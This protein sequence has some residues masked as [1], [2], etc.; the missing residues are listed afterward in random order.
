M[1]L[2]GVTEAAAVALVLSFI[3]Y[4]Q[5]AVES[6]LTELVVLG[7]VRDAR[8][9]DLD[10]QSFVGFA[11]TSHTH[12]VILSDHRGCGGHAVGVDRVGVA[13]TV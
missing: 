5:T 8:H 11:L 3:V 2:L 9:R 4:G 13:D 1:S 10:E 12:E 6:D 7:D